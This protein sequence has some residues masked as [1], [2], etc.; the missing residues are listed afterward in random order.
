M[1]RPGRTF[2]AER[3]AS[4]KAELGADLVIAN[5]E[6]AAGGAGITKKIAVAL[7]A[8]G[9]DAI[10]LGDHVWDQKNFENEIDGLALRKP[11]SFGHHYHP[12][13]QLVVSV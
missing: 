6:N 11:R 10:T 2:V 9:V 3:V 5:A 13:Y 7:I 4:L 1:G 8:A 12:H